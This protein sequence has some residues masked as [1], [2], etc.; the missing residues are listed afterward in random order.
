MAV[1]TP[2]VLVPV[3]SVVVAEDGWRLLMSTL[4]LNDRDDAPRFIKPV[5]SRDALRASPSCCLRSVLDRDN[6]SLFMSKSLYA[7]LRETSSA[8]SS[9]LEKGKKNQSGNQINLFKGTIAK[10]P[11]GTCSMKFTSITN[12]EKNKNKATFKYLYQK[13]IFSSKF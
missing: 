3:V 13:N 11:R 2:T 12:V 7:A 10:L 9:L 5:W 8:S 1:A 4:T 6:T